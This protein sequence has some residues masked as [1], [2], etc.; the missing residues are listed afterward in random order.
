MTFWQRLL[1]L[2]GDSLLALSVIL[3]ILSLLNL[4]FGK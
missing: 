1:I 2:W 4:F 3:L